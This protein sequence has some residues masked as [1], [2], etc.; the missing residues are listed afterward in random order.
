MSAHTAKP[1]IPPAGEQTSLEVD[2]LTEPLDVT[3]SSQIQGGVD[4]RLDHR[5]PIIEDR[6][7]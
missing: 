6:S 7:Q 2:A 4:G 5:K 3:G 1:T